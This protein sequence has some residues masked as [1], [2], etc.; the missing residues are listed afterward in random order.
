[1]DCPVVV[2]IDLEAVRHLPE[3]APAGGRDGFGSEPE[4]GSC[5]ETIGR[6]GEAQQRSLEH[7]PHEGV[8]VSRAHSGTLVT[9]RIGGD[10]VGCQWTSVMCCGAISRV[11][12]ML[13]D[14]I[15]E[16]SSL[17]DLGI[18]SLAVAEI[19]VEIEAELD[20]ELP[21]HLFR[22]LDDVRTVGDVERELSKSLA[23]P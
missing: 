13:L 14:R 10:G 7:G 8:D 4:R 17:D 18:D 2:L 16:D 1:M 6:R 11:C 9:H 21:V 23:P 15:R 3:S 20:R 22:Q 19:I 5:P 12:D